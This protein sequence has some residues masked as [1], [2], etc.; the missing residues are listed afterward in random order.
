LDITAEDGAARIP[1]DTAGS[2]DFWRDLMQK[3]EAF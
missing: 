2:W 1:K 3:Q